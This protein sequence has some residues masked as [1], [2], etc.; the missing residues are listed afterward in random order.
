MARVEKA[1]RKVATSRFEEVR[2]Q[3]AVRNIVQGFRRFNRYQA[4][5][6]NADID[7]EGWFGV[8]EVCAIMDPK[9]NYEHFLHVVH[10]HL[11]CWFRSKFLRYNNREC[12]DVEK[13]VREG[14]PYGAEEF[15]LELLPTPNPTPDEIFAAGEIA[16][17]LE[18]KVIEE[19]DAALFSLFLA[20][21]Y[22]GDDVAEELRKYIQADRPRKKKFLVPAAVYMK[23]LGCSKRTFLARRDRLREL[24]ESVGLSPDRG[25]R[26]HAGERRSK[27][28]DPECQEQVSA[29]L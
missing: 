5:Y 23:T 16:R 9:E 15:E 4:R 1:N 3:K 27:E 17:E 28:S 2:H 14:H 8:W 19:N 22:P 26:V 24:A 21:V 6:D 12:R 13:E 7:Q 25:V 29:E 18:E 11:T 20:M 10:H